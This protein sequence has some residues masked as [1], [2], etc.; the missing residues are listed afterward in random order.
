[1]VWW[2]L[3]PVL[4]SEA[5][6]LLCSVFFSMLS[7]GM[8]WHSALAHP[9]QQWRLALSLFLLITAL[10]ALLLGL[11]VNRWTAKPLLSVLLVVTAVAA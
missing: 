6:I 7:N 9:L 3:R 10:H 4:A 11:V 5:L 1:M 2:K 8:F